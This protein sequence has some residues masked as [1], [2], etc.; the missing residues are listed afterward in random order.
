MNKIMNAIKNN[1][2]I[3]MTA[4]GLGATV[5]GVIF[6]KKA[7]IKAKEILKEHMDNKEV[8]ENCAKEVPAEVYSEQDKENDIC[9]NN[10]QTVVKLVKNYS[11]PIGITAIGM[12]TMINGIIIYLS[13]TNNLEVT[14][15]NECKF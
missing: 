2:G 3:L 8:I 5:T 13:K 15:S 10:V 14:V 6:T 7:N 9:I 12:Y 1:K 11:L 4:G